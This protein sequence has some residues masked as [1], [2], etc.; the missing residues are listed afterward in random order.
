MR[1]LVSITP[2]RGLTGEGA[3]VTRAQL[4]HFVHGFTLRFIPSSAIADSRV[5]IENLH[6]PCY[7]TRK[8]NCAQPCFVQYLHRIRTCLSYALE[9]GYGVKQR[10][11][12]GAAR[13]L[14]EPWIHEHIS[15]SPG[16]GRWRLCLVVISCSFI[17]NVC[18]SL[19]SIIRYRGLRRRGT[20]HS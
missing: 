7:T 8:S 6:M 18:P 17:H 1:C 9:E 15:Q 2:L 14:A 12:P 5:S 3:I 11:R 19:Y 10:V 13:R 4:V 20:K 16:N